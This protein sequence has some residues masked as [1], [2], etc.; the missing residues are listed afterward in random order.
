MFAATQS[1]ARIWDEQILS[2]I[3]IDKP[4]PPVH[5]RNLFSLS[6]VMYDAWAAY[7][8]NSVGFIYHTKHTA[9]DIAAARREAI[10]YAAYRML[11]ERFALSKSASNTL[12]ALNARMNTLGYPTNN[13]SLDTSTPAGVGN[14]VYLAV[15][16]WF[17]N[18]G[19]L[20]SRAYAD[21]PPNQGGYAPINPPLVTGLPGTFPADVSRWQPLAITN[22]FDQ[23]GLANSNVVQT[24]LGSQWLWVRPFA[25]MRSDTNL[26]FIDPGPPPLLGNDSDAAFRS[27]IVACILASSQLSP[28]DGVI[29]DASPA[30]VGNNS[31]NAIDGSGYSL[32]PITGQPYQTNLVKRGDWTRVMAEFWADGPNSETPPGHWNVIANA[33]ADSPLTI[34][35]IGGIGPVVDDLEWDV[36][37]YFALNASV[38]D[39]A[40]AAWGLKR[41]YDA[42]RPISAIRYMGEL[43][44]SS[45]PELPAYNENGL[46]LITNLIELVTQDSAASGGRHQGLTPNTIAI[47]TWPGVPADPTNQHSSVQWIFAANWMPYQKASFV[48]PAFPGYISGHST[49]SRAAA[50]VLTAITG[51]P[52]YPGG[53]GT[54]T[55]VSNSFLTFEQGPSQ[56]IQLQWAT[57]DDAADLAGLS[58]IWGGIHPPIDNIVGRKVGSQVGLSTWALARKYFDG[59]ITNFVPTLAIQK[60]DNAC[61]LIYSAV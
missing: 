18:D 4:H 48:T 51:S 53:L 14:S 19:S 54:F 33:V 50:E 9:A 30:S 39:A 5:A 10:S 34:K 56:T 27:N 47:H 40:C 43:G 21:F 23:N 11:A 15:S 52:F 31:L 12:F 1:I 20:Q 46:P 44:Q 55:A 61:D 29:I 22:A 24:F 13:T 8:S 49:F 57:Y 37:V 28:D 59:S 32:N 42:W 17:I 16:A 35:R 58:R 25:L 38:H 7:D 45:D 41:Y 2:S 3:R 36:K 60:D 26:P 6:A